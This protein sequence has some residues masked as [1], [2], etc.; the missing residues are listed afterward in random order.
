M[1]VFDVPRGTRDY[2]PG[3]MSMRDELEKK[4]RR[5]LALYGFQHVQTPIVERADLFKDHT[6]T[7]IEEG[8]FSIWADTER[9]VLR[10]ELTVPICRFVASSNLGENGDPIKLFYS[11]PCFR[12][13]RPQAGVYREFFQIG[14]ELLGVPDAVADAEVI[15]VAVRVLNSLE[16]PNYTL[17]IGNV[18]IFQALLNP[19]GNPQASSA[20]GT[21]RNEIIH[22]IERITHDCEYCDA[23][24]QQDTLLPHNENYIS[25]LEREIC[26]LQKSVGFPAKDALAPSAATNGSELR[27]RLAA[28]AEAISATYRHGWLATGHVSEADADLFVQLAKMRGKGTEIFDSARRLLGT[29]RANESLIHLERTCRCLEAF[30]VDNY[31][32]VL[33]TVRNLDFYTDTVFEID[34]PSLGTDRQVCGGGRYDE[35]ANSIGGPP[36]PATGF[37][38][39][40]DRLVSLV[41]TRRQETVYD[42]YI[43]AEDE[44]LRVRAIGVAELLRE[45]VGELG[46]IFRIVA[47]KINWINRRR[48]MPP[49]L[50]FST[51]N[52]SMGKLVDCELSTLHSVQSK[53]ELPSHR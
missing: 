15:T 36:M 37:A 45:L 21:W 49:S 51:R 47:L 7:E 52:P 24:T 11:G 3:E 38:F 42:I 2:A 46:L 5:I 9:W 22:S 32:V 40:F 41:A 39:A 35:L 25:L 26:D 29:T 16:I 17:K 13:V 1:A 50:L 20:T 43:C 48:S 6:G 28:L 31:E 30:G 23:M 12:Y 10:P 18:G 34:V 19:T 33:G 14:V 44:K 27:L 53:S 8:L 4:I